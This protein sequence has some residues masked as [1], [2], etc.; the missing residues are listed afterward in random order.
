MFILETMQKIW[1]R[2]SKQIGLTQNEE[3]LE[4]KKEYRLRPWHT[5]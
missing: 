5:N 1:F 3:V 4:N 2:P